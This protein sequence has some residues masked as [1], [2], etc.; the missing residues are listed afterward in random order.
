MNKNTMMRA[1]RII[2]ASRPAY[3]T[4]QICSSY[5]SSNS[6][7][8]AFLSKRCR[9]DTQGSCI[10]CD[11]GYSNVSY[12]DEEYIDE[13][14]KI[15]RQHPNAESILLCTNGSFLDEQQISDEL[16]RKILRVAT[17]S[18]IKEIQIETHYNDINNSKLDL[19]K[20]MCQNK[21]V[22]IELGFET[23]NQFYQDNIIM[24]HIDINKFEYVL[25]KIQSY[26]FNTILNIM[27]GLPLLSVKDQVTDTYETINWALNHNCRAVVFPINIK[28]YTLLWHMYKNN[29]YNPISHWAIIFLLTMFKNKDLSKITLAWYGDRDEGDPDTED[30]TI[31]PL[32]CNICSPKL[33]EFYEQFNNIKDYHRR[34]ELLQSIL[35][36]LNFCDCFCHFMQKYCSRKGESFE[37]NY[38]KYIERIKIDFKI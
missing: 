28:P 18:E 15:I 38:K 27:L 31:F 12:T 33:M 4:N 14:R 7:E 34:N 37:L 5:Y 20:S 29:F 13:M 9:N 6:L 1:N 35:N 36:E 19:I 23:S 25:N 32:S 30:E 24:K 3:L 11:Y 2:R 16:L 17:N 21:I 22:T 26:G 10:M 8:I